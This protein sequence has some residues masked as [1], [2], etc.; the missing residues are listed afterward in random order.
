MNS[1][2][3]VFEILDSV[4]EVPESENPVKPE[5]VLGEVEF[6]NVSFGYEKTRK[7]LDDV[8]F[9]VS[10]GETI[11]IVGETGAGKSTLVN[12]LVRL[13]DAEEGSVII[14][15]CDVKDLSF[16][17]LHSMVAIVS[18]ETYLFRGTIK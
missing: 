9:K 17:D 14:D 7:I 18:Q 4:T 8:S 6:R 11:G 12:L 15:G 1:V 5:R 16:E 10:A 3:R 13:Y 2:H